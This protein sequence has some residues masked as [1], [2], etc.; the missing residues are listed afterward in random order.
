MVLPGRSSSAAGTVSINRAGVP[1]QK[2]P[3]QQQKGH[4][5][6][7]GGQNKNPAWNGPCCDG[8]RKVGDGK[9]SAC[10]C[11]CARSYFVCM[12]CRLPLALTNEQ[13]ARI[14]TNLNAARELRE[15]KEIHVLL[16]RVEKEILRKRGMEE[17]IGSWQLTTQ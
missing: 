4:H 11:G 1:M 16:D 5:F 3:V 13:R 17:Q 7:K 9:R 2:A 10:Q 8:H 6:K 15:D 14:R 12:T